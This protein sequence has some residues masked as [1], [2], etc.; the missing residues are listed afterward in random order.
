MLDME[1][2]AVKDSVV[3]QAHRMVET[4]ITIQQLV[5]VE[6]QAVKDL[7]VIQAVHHHHHKP[8]VMVVLALCG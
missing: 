7:K 3:V 6:A 4:L 8:V 2:T 5:A 1:D